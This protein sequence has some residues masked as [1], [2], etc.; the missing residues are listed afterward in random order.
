MHELLLH[1]LLHELLLHGL[2]LQLLLLHKL[3]QRLQLH[4]V[5]RGLGWLR[6]RWGRRRSWC[7]G[8]MMFFFRRR[9]GLR[10][11]TLRGWMRGWVRRRVLWRWRVMLWMSVRIHVRWHATIGRSTVWWVVAH[12]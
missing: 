12:W 11:R 6:L 9:L 10:C 1:G 2:L 5:S 8:D 4:L 7:S 3:L